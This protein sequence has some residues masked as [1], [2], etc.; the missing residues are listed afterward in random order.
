[1]EPPARLYHDWEVKRHAQ[2]SRQIHNSDDMLCKACGLECK[3]FEIQ[4]REIGEVCPGEPA[5]EEHVWMCVHRERTPGMSTWECRRCNVTVKDRDM[6]SISPNCPKGKPLPGVVRPPH[7][8]HDWY[9]RTVANP[10]HQQGS[11]ARLVRV[12]VDS[13]CSICGEVKQ[14]G[15]VFRNVDEVCPSPWRGKNWKTRGEMAI[16]RTPQSENDH[17]WVLESDPQTKRLLQ[18]MK[19]SRC[20]L[21]ASRTDPRIHIPIDDPLGFPDC[22]WEPDDE[23]ELRAAQKGFGESSE[24]PDEGER[25]R[26]IGL[27]VGIDCA[28][29]VTGRKFKDGRVIID[30]PLNDIFTI[31][32]PLD[33]GGRDDLVDSVRYSMKA[34]AE[35]SRRSGKSERIREIMAELR[36]KSR[37]PLMTVDSVSEAFRR[38]LEGDFKLSIPRVESASGLVMK[39][40]QLA[41]ILL[42]MPEKLLGKTPDPTEETPVKLGRAER[43]KQERQNRRK[44]SP[45]RER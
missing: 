39:D 31:D 42:R 40:Q 3:R 20:G 11:S 43:R 12:P 45:W 14:N 7:R 2:P 30:D 36:T 41:D 29:V 27:E 1:L 35:L 6:H 17:V 33:P 22:E 18:T 8:P 19:C 16:V 34:L 10:S 13:Y 37:E 5:R 38:E 26:C 24:R 21:E 15:G 4:R 23:D 25:F 32:P 28:T 44:R 9:M